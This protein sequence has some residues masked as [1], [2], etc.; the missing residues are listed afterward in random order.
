MYKIVMILKIIKIT[1]L[2][3]LHQVVGEGESKITLQEL[4]IKVNKKYTIIIKNMTYSSLELLFRCCH[5]H[6]G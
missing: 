4:N 6:R 1:R 2:P 3:K 5:Y